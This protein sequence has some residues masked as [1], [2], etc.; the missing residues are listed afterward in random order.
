MTPR[1]ISQRLAGEAEPICRELLPNGK[2]KG[3]E[4]VVGSIHGEEGESMQVHLSGDKAGVWKDFSSS[5]K[6]GDL[7]DLY[8]QTQGA[9]IREAI[10]WAKG[11]LGIEDRLP[12]KPKN[13]RKPE[14]PKCQAPKAQVR[15]WLKETRKLSDE[16]ISAYKIA[17]QNDNVVFP[18]LRDGELVFVKYR[19]INDKKKMRVE[20]GCEPILFGWQAIPDD[21]RSVIICEGEIDAPSWWMAGL[22]AMSVPNGA[23]GHTWIENE[24]DNLERFDEILIAFDSDKPGQDG[25]MEVIERL[26]RERCKLVTIPSP[27]KDAN[28]VLV[29]RGTDELA[30]QLGKAKPVDPATL[31]HASHYHDDVVA[32]MTG[33]EN[34]SGYSLPW[35]KAKNK[36]RLRDGELTILAGENHH[37]KSQAVGH[38]T[39]GA[40]AREA[41]ACVASLEYVP[42]KWLASMGRQASAL[43]P[44]EIMPEYADRVSRWLSENLWVFDAHDT[45]GIDSILE[46]F[47]Y[48]KNRYNVWLFVIDNLEMCDSKSD[49]YEG[50]RLIAQRLAAFARKNGVHVILVHHMAKNSEHKNRHAIKGSGS[51]TNLAHNV[52]IWKRMEAKENKIE[53]LAIDL[54]GMEQGPEYEA[55]MSQIE[56]EQKKADAIMDIDKQRETGDRC[57]FFLWFDKNSR[58]FKGSYDDK[59]V[60]YVK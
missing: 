29:E 6:G 55:I 5:D 21:A 56:T 9:T 13:Y 22:P 7:I 1:E 4:W 40:L 12:E 20:A 17:E 48:A 28:D 24:Y 43:S 27:W 49:D 39:L 15:Q 35:E 38:I 58:Q 16:A 57:K 8:M 54:R 47:Q 25:A 19:N 23:N 3:S 44:D 51:L 60:Q 2:R 10:E 36:F 18:Y 30:K 59:P 41:R 45:A 37:G 42:Q 52:I 50:Q 14:K 31:K 32:L 34:T 33:K 53:E 26:G 11:Y 46:T